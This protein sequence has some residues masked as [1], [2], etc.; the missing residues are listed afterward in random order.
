[1]LRC[2]VSWKVK[3]TRSSSQQN[4][5][6][7]VLTQ[8]RPLSGQSVSLC[9]GDQQV[10][11]AP[12]HSAS[13]R[14]EAAGHWPASS[15]SP[16]DPPSSEK[17]GQ[18]QPSPSSPVLPAVPKAPSASPYSPALASQSTLNL[19]ICPVLCTLYSVLCTLEDNN[20]RS[21]LQPPV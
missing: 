6:A 18:S 1:M 9:P 8:Q 14:A 20:N 16:P 5:L 12:A 4:V 10:E 7:L 15:P 21:D 2:S 13:D 11:T 17:D 3:M 19:Q